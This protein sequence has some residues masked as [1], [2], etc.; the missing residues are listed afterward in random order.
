MSARFRYHRRPQGWTWRLLEANNRAIA[1]SSQ[2]HRD[3]TLALRDAQAVALLATD[4]RIEVVG[5]GRGWRWVLLDDD[6]VRAVSAGVFVR[7]SDCIRAGTR[8]RLS[9]VLAR[10]DPPDGDTAAGDTAAGDSSVRSPR[11]A[12]PPSAS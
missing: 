7:R 3:P 2:P 11:P 12:R 4:G 10:L 1:Q 6:G 9:V 5:G 8:F